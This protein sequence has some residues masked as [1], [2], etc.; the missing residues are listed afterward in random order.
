MNPAPS[1]NSVLNKKEGMR[2]FPSKISKRLEMNT[3][4]GAG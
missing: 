2:W 3:K 4:E 1:I